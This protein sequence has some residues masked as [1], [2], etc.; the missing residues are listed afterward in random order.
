M[1]F[2]TA[3][4]SAFPSS[5]AVPV[6]TTLTVY[7][8]EEAAQAYRE[9]AKGIL[10]PAGGEPFR[11]APGFVPSS[12]ADAL[13]VYASPERAYRAADISKYLGRNTPR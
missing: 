12:E 11:L 5:V 8:Q 4:R 1:R 3:S 6:N 9:A 10:R 13:K 2:V 7:I